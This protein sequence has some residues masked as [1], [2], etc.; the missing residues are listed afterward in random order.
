MARDQQQMNILTAAGQAATNNVNQITP[1]GTLTYQHISDFDLGN[2]NKVPQWQATQ[3]LSPEQQ[4]LYDTQTNLSQ[5]FMDLGKEYVGRIRDAT[6]TPFNYEGLPS[7]PVYDEIFRQ[8]MKDQIVARNQPQQDRMKAQLE[9]Q[10]ADRGVGMQDPA[11]RTAQDQYQRGQNDFLLGADL[12]AGQEAQN[13]FNLAA[14]TR[15]R[16]IQERANLRTQPINEVAGLI[17][18]G[19][20]GVRSPQFVNTPQTQIANTDTY[21]PYAMQQQQALAQQQMATQSNNAM[22]GGLFGLGSS[23][24][25]GGAFLL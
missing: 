8:R 18:Q 7:A 4:K 23:A 6:A 20:G 16:A 11:Y 13:A 10:L 14:T 17:N 15:D 21:A 1:F 2:G 3:V 19:A 24:M 5:S 9:Q 22:M 12:Q 25:M